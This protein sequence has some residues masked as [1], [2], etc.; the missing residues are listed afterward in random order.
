M[1]IG[2]VNPRQEMEISFLDESF[3]AKGQNGKKFLRP[4][5]SEFPIF[6][7]EGRQSAESEQ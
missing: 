5:E 7:K 1:W 6:G 2:Q 3:S 4:G